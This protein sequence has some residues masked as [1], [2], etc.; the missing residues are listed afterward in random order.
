MRRTPCSWPESPAQTVIP[1]ESIEHARSSF[2]QLGEH[3]EVLE[4]DELRNAIAASA[5]AIARRYASGVRAGS[6]D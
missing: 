4:P 6:T 1:I 2:M 3:L 5:A